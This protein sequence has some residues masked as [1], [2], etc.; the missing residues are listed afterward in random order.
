MADEK[1]P[2]INF[3]HRRQDDL[4]TEGGGKEKI[5]SWTLSGENLKN[6][7]E[8]LIHQLEGILQQNKPEIEDYPY[9][10]EVKFIDAAKAKSHQSKLIS[11]FNVDNT[12]SQLGM[13]NGNQLLLKLDHQE[14]V[15]KAI[16][17]FSELERNK[18][19]ISAIKDIKGF[20]A[21]L[22]EDEEADLYKI[23]FIDFHNEKLNKQVIEYVE[24]LLIKKGVNFERRLYGVNNQILEVSEV[25]FD[26]LNFIKELPVK[27]IEP[28]PKTENPFLDLELNN[29]EFPKFK[30]FDSSKKYPVVGL[31][32]SGVEILPELEGFVRRGLGCSYSDSELNTNHGTFIASLLIHGNQINTVNDYSIDG[33]I[34]VDVPVVK[35]G[36]VSESIL[37]SNVRNAIASNPE[38]KIWNLSVSV[39]GENFN[40][41]QFSDFAIALDE[42]QDEFD[43]LICKS[44]GNDN[45]SYLKGEEPKKISIGADSVRA[46]TVGSICRNS[47]DNGFSKKDFPSP[48]SRIGRGPAEIIKPDLVH[49]GGD[50]FSE[51][52]NPLSKDDYDFKGEKSLVSNGALYT[53]PGTSYSTPKI[54]KLIAELY[55]AF[56]MNP[57]TFDALLLKGLAIHSSTYLENPA[58]D[59]LERLRR[60]GY[61]KPGNSKYIMTQDTPDSVTLVLNGNLKKKQ[62]I[63]IMDFPYPKDLV[64]DGKFIGEIKV[65]LVYKNYLSKEM[66]PEY[67]Q[68][69]MVLRMGTYDRLV[70]RDTS[71]P[72]ILNPIGRAD[73]QNL[74]LK[75]AY[76]VKKIKQNPTFSRERSLIEFGDKYYPVKKFSANLEEA[77]DSIQRASLTKDKKW[78]LFIEGQYRDFIYKEFNE[79][80]SQLSMDYALIITISDPEK[81]HNVYG[82]TIDELE[83]HNFEYSKI[84]IENHI[85]IYSGSD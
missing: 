20:T 51:I 3:K 63:D 77:K 37:I 64:K 52:P 73:S 13:I 14:A 2:L 85:D 9:V 30:S 49:Y 79:D 33:C 43:V 84:D 82:N 46:L 65:S 56:D 80:D 40:E 11:M 23:N 27:K 47:D 4:R 75:A 34:V 69:N 24:K 29:K 57:A 21:Y 50:V 78:F 36:G 22:L 35:D 19:S 31:L 18:N 16:K 26:K 74:L 17:N 61:G 38:I 1:Y 25:T 60:I 58:M 54:A 67:C 66:G 10:L 48:Y 55:L 42:I 39:I 45:E 59:G 68:S 41:N 44:A 62:R 53:M 32:D 72:T 6:H 12:K 7:S 83:A 76:G 81:S 5:Y 70:G 8:V 15:K 28:M 71:M